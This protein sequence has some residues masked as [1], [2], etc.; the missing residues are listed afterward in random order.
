[1]TKLIEQ[2]RGGVAYGMTMPGPKPTWAPPGEAGGDDDSGG[3]DDGTGDDKSGG[4][5]D[6]S[7]GDDKGDQKAADPKLKGGL[8]ANRT[9]EGQQEDKTGDDKADDGKPPQIPAKFL[10]KDGKP[11]V[12]SMAKAYADLE[13]AHGELKR[14]K[15][16]GGGEVPEAAGDYFKD[17]VTVPEE[18]ANFKGLTVDDPGVKSWA[19]TCKEEGI[20]KDLATRLF[21][22]MLI[23]MDGLAPAPLDP[24]AEFASLGKGGPALVDGLFV[25]C[26]GMAQ[27]GDLSENDVAE[28]ERMMQTANGARLLAKFRNMA[29]EKPI[30]VDPGSNSRGMSQDQLDEA[31]KAAVKKGDYAEQ[32]RLDALRDTINPEGNAPGISGRHGGYSI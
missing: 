27:A 9:K 30:P 17:G 18:A 16:P 8:F 20:G 2:L 25:W 1:M 10:D 4:A 26:E 24:E 23:K 31:Y 21:T 32:A 28:V 3:G 14:T 5:D 6:K 12:D 19:E 15:G 13:K 11:N 29:G 7:G 22:K